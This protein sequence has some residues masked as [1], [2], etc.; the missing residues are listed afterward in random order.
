MLQLI[1]ASLRRNL[2]FPDPRS[3]IHS[4]MQTGTSIPLAPRGT[5][6]LRMCLSLAMPAAAIF[7]AALAQHVLTMLWPAL[8]RLPFP[9]A[10]ADSYLVV[11][12]TGVLCFL[13]GGFLRRRVQT[14]TGLFCALVAPLLF[15]G[16]LLWSAFGPAIRAA[17][18]GDI[19]WLRAMTL[20]IIVSACL[21]LAAVALGWALSRRRVAD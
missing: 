21:P 15:A 4:G 2:S 10:S 11:L 7:A 5:S 13:A 18:L 9:V 14:R 12:L 6:M 17:G 20:F 1:H 3:I 19:A 8:R 16:F